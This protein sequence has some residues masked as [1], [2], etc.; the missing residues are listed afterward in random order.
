M[1]NKM[2][3]YPEIRFNQPWLLIDTIYHD[4]KGAYEKPNDELYKLDPKFINRTLRRYEKAW[5][6][7][8]EQ[9]IHGMCDLLGIEF[10]QN[11]IDIYAAPFYNSFSDPM[12]IATK[13]SSKRV[14]EEITHEL[15]H[16]LLTDNAQTDY[17][18][19]YVNE[20]KKL[21][22]D[23]L[24]WNTLVH[25]P[26]HAVLQALFDDVLDEPERTRN[27]KR[28]CKQWPDYDAAWKYV[29]KVGYKTIIEQLRES[30]KRLGE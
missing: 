15:L 12:F 25:V 26:V 23:G 10:R 2:M 1:Y 5:R 9:I 24:S 28:L 14:V 6:P 4:I 29:D 19:N 20:W 16:R 17:K 21:F 27:D 22:K 13:F 18:T 30:Y 7:Y 8:E 11:I 3:N